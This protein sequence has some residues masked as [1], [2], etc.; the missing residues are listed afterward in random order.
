MEKGFVVE[1]EKFTGLQY[2]TTPWRTRF[3]GH[4]FTRAAEIIHLHNLHGN[5]FSPLILPD[6]SRIAPLVWTLHDTWAL[7]GHCTYTYDCERWQTG[8]G[9]C[10]NLEEH[11][12]I[13][14]DTTAFLWRKK[15]D[16]YQGSDLTVVAP[17]SWLADMARRSP[18]LGGFE[19]HHIPYGL[20]LAS[21]RPSARPKARQELGIPVDAA[22]VMIIVLPGGERKGHDY[23]LRALPQLRSP[24]KLW[25]LVVGSEGLFSPVPRG[26]SVRETGYVTSF[27]EMLKCYSASDLIVLPTTADNLPVTVLEAAACGIPAVAFKVGGVP[28][29][30]RHMQTGYLAMAKDTSDLAKGLDT[31]LEND[32]LRAVLGSCAQKMVETEYS[33]DIQV[34]RYEALYQATRAKREVHSC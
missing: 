11:P 24:Q 4:P 6:L 5:F 16:L 28:D 32:A 26:I 22:V 33:A 1:F 14:L 20:D 34:R 12:K 8:C 29:L 31:L 17:S 30:V 25:I 2:L 9:R 15:K 21:I 23:L 19:I 3:V 10:P 13:C 7:T 18:L 27:E